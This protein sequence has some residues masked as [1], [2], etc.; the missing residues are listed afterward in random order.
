MAMWVCECGCLFGCQFLDVWMYFCGWMGVIGCV[1]VLV[2]S[3]DL[4]VF[5][6]LVIFVCV[7]S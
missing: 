4:Y 5:I 6:L 7:D 3:S 2:I 1:G